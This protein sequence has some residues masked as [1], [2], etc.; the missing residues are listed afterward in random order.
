VEAKLLKTFPV[1]LDLIFSTFAFIAP[2]GFAVVTLPN[3]LV[4]FPLSGTNTDL[5]STW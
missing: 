3:S 4:Q 2:S 5:E 1:P